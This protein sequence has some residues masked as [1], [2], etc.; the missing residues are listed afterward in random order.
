ML[1]DLFYSI[2]L[3]ITDLKTSAKATKEQADDIKRGFKNMGDIFAAGGITAAVVGFFSAAIDYA[4]NLKGQ[5]SDNIAA[6]QRWAGAWK[7]FKEYILEKG[8]EIVGVLAG[9]GE[10]GGNIVRGVFEG[11]GPAWEKIKSLDFNGA[12]AEIAAAQTDVNRIDQESIEINKKIAEQK[13]RNKVFSEETKRLN[14]QLVE[15]EKQRNALTLDGMTTQEKINALVEELRAA[16]AAEAEHTTN[17]NKAKEL[18]LKTQQ[19]ELDLVKELHKYDKEQEKRE[20]EQG[21]I[22]QKRLDA[23]RETLTVQQRLN[24]LKFEEKVLIEAIAEMDEDQPEY[25]ESQNR[26]LDVQNKLRGAVKEQGN[27]NVEIARL[28][29][30]GEENLTDAEKEKLALLRGQT[31]EAK[32]RAEVEQLL[33]KGVAN[34]TDAEKARLAALTGGTAEY[35]KQ[36][37]EAQKLLRTT[38]EIRGRY[39]DDLSDLLLEDKIR[40]IKADVLSRRTAEQMA[41]ASVGGAYYDP[42]MSF[43]QNQLK[44]AQDELAARE[45]IRQRVATYGEAGAAKFYQ[46][47]MVEYERLLEFARN[48]PEDSKNLKRLADSLERF[49]SRFDK[50]PAKR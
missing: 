25:I 20:K 8:A 15:V 42:L 45:M 43:Q 10:K 30:K 5:V 50:L 26:L 18:K 32:Q 38:M 21:T 39:N 1:S 34:L 27:A 3:D 7:E 6:T 37:D 16:R 33:A 47:N 4:S 40:T 22:I 13:E 36:N 49:D 9:I 48:T 44:A 24:I 17:D 11:I 23:E 41:G 2:G 28:L 46:G 19:L 14:E 35:R 31:T 29:L 12:I